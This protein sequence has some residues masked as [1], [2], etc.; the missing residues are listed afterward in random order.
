MQVLERIR[1]RAARNLDTKGDADSDLSIRV[2]IT[3]TSHELQTVETKACALVSPKLTRFIP[4]ALYIYS[5]L[6][7]RT[8]GYMAEKPY[9]E[10]Y[11]DGSRY[12]GTPV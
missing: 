9:R 2:Q 10:T 1:C 8:S 3:S 12:G 11:R 6:K 4:R 5:I 7:L